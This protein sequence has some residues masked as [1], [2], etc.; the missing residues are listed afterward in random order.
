MFVFSVKTSYKQILSALGCVAVVA[1]AVIAATVMPPEQAV[2][3][4]GARVTS[5]EERVSYLRSLGL[6]IKEDSEEVR[7]VRIPDEP[8]QT[9]Q[10]YNTLQEQA[11]RSLEAYY[12]KRV[13]LY[14][15]E[16]T[17][18]GAAHLY[19]YRDRIVA[20]DVELDGQMQALNG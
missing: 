12:G 16:V 1:V 19:V 10:Q 15:Y 4:S 20:G 8:D 3:V 14:S 13:R 5:S 2:V 6:E 7:E 17:N 11:G 9:L 18:G